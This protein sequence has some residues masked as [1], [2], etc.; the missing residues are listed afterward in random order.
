[1]YKKTS[2]CVCTSTVVMFPNPLSPAEIE[3][4]SDD[5][6]RADEGD[7]RIKYSCVKFCSLSKGA[8]RKSYV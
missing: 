8:V 1:M 6:E 7:I 4:D 5:P 3:E 2:K